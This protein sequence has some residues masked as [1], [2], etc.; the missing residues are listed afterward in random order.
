MSERRTVG[1]GLG[2]LLP[3]FGVTATWFCCLPLALSGLGAGA[4]GIGT[5]LTPARPY[6]IALSVAFLGLAFYNAY[7]PQKRVCGPD[8]SCPVSTS[9]WR[10]RTLL[11][12]VAVASV[13][14]ITVDRWGSWV[15][16]WML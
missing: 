8:G 4:A 10:Q 3:A 15:I 12:I 6:F 1:L 7:R 5:A 14:L 11:W 16:F 13:A 9:R 2:A